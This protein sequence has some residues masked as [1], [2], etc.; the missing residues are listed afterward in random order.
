QVGTQSRSV[1]HYREAIEYIQSGKLGKVHMAKAWNSQLRRRVP[2]VADA[3]VPDGLD[4]EMWLGPATKKAFNANHYT[5]G[6]RWLWEYGTG[7]M[8]N[9]G[10]HDLDIARWALG[11]EAPDSANCTGAKF[12]FE[13]D[14]QEV[15][16]T[17]I[18]TFTFPGTKAVLVYEQ[19]LWS[20]YFQEGHENG[21]AV[22]GTEGYMIL[23]RSGYKVIGPKNKEVMTKTEKFSD[24][25]HHE[26]FLASIQGRPKPNCATEGGPR[27]TSLAPRGTIAN[28]VARPLK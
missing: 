20:P 19:R 3:K 15:P 8:G 24:I 5:S 11:V 13:G 17:Q 22:Y 18:V 12:F 16:D 14:I 1:P 23:G 25:P 21:V 9:D 4:W 2:A 28:R 26:N 10:V 6:W 7:D 27:P